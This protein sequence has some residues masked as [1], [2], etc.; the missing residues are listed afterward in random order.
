MHALVATLRIVPFQRG[1]HEDPHF[2]SELGMM[3]N[4]KVQNAAS[5]PPLGKMG[6]KFISRVAQA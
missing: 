2:T 5:S 3:G 4:V 1:A 6:R